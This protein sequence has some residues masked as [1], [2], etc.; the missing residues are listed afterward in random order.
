MRDHVQNRIPYAEMDS[1]LASGAGLALFVVLLTA[2]IFAQT[3]AGTI[4]LN[5]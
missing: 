5:P 1:I 3:T 4:G 2:P